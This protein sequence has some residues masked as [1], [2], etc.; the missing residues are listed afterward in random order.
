MIKDKVIIV[1]GSEGSLGQEIVKRFGFENNVIG[2][3]KEILSVV[4]R[5]YLTTF[6]NLDLLNINSVEIYEEIIKIYGRI[7]VVINNAGI[8]DIDWLENQ[9]DERFDK[10][11]Q[12]NLNVPF[13]MMRD[14]VRLCSALEYDKDYNNYSKSGLVNTRVNNQY[15]KIVI[16]ISS[17]ASRY[18]LRAS[19]SYN[20]SKAGLV[21]LTKQI[22]RE[23]GDR[24]KD[25]VFYCISPNGLK[26]SNMIEYCINKLQTVRGFPDRESAVKYNKQSPIGDLQNMSEIVDQI[27]FL[28]EHRPLYL[29]GSNIENIGCAQ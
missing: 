28:I 11:I 24:H 8:T 9:T 5:S 18:S 7:D 21:H 27:E 17:M 29:S 2:I 20:A 13:K 16:N 26:D 10:V 3:D 23:L 1:T 22:A 6:Y 15:E 25:F 12:T 4:G 14:Y 19:C